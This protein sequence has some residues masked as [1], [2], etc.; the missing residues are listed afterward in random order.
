MAAKG[1]DQLIAAIIAAIFQNSANEIDGQDLQDQLVDV[2]DSLNQGL[3]NNLVPYNIGQSVI[4]DNGGAKE[5]YVCVTATTA[6]ESPITTPAKWDLTSGSGV[7]LDEIVL[8]VSALKA[9][10]GYSDD[11]Q[12]LI[13]DNNGLYGFD[14]TSTAVNDDDLVII[15]DDKFHL[16]EGNIKH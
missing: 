4:I 7:A 6:G 2:V 9:V 14:D 1:I 16:P 11:D 10:T 8:S 3:Y 13:N 5:L 15:P 12:A